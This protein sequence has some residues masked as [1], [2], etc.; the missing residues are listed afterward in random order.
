MRNAL[1]T[2]P[3]ITRKV[4]V[5]TVAHQLLCLCG[6][7]PVRVLSSC[8]LALS[9]FDVVMKPSLPIAFFATSRPI[10]VYS[11]GTM[12]PISFLEGG[13]F[14]PSSQLQTDAIGRE[15]KFIPVPLN[16]IG[17]VYENKWRGMIT[18]DLGRDYFAINWFVLTKRWSWVLLG[19]SSSRVNCYLLSF[20]SLRIREVEHNRKKIC[21]LNIW[22]YSVP[23][24]YYE[25]QRSRRLTIPDT[26]S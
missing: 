20:T 3:P 19:K 26:L 23:G 7:N 1:C 24:S 9:T 22:T 4:W 10:V 6:R 11:Q 18:P 14:L 15:R 2:R 16:K 5:Y 17:R 13:Y 8:V 12:R 21:F 25:G